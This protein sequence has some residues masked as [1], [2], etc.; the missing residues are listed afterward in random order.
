MADPVY[1]AIDRRLSEFFILGQEADF[2][3]LSEYVKDVYEQGYEDGL[4]D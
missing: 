2:D 1:D 3:A 4:N